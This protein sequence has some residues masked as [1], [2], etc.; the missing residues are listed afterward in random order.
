M[1]RSD[2][3]AIAAKD[4]A[5]NVVIK[6]VGKVFTDKGDAYSKDCKL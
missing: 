6:T 4:T 3:R 2:V 5:G 1:R